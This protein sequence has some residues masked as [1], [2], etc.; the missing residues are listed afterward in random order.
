MRSRTSKPNLKTGSKPTLLN[1]FPSTWKRRRL[2]N[3]SN[4]SSPSKEYSQV[5]I[6]VVIQSKT[7]SFARR[8]YH[9]H[10]F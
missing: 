2:T 3:G 10:D 1:I 9:F 6:V 4:D 8:T 7:P 5:A